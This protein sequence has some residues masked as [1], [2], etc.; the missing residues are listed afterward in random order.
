MSETSKDNLVALAKGG[1]IAGMLAFGL[2]IIWGALE[3]SQEKADKLNYERYFDLKTE[4]NYIK[5]Q[6]KDCQE[7]KENRIEQGIEYIIKKLEL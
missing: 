4:Q 5:E 6:L 7:N 2:W 3:T 1:S